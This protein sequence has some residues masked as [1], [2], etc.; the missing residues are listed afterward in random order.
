[1]FD[2]IFGLPMHPLVVHATVVVVPSARCRRD[3]RRLAAFRR[4]AGPL[5]LVLSV[6]SLVLVP[7]STSSGESLERTSRRRPAAPAHRD[8][9]RA[10]RLGHHPGRRRGRALLADQDPQDSSPALVTVV[11]SVLAAV[12]VVG[13]VV[14]VVRIGHSGA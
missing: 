13:T 5:P 4:W 8:G 2:T 1:M 9:R 14:Q 12:G 3:G 10:A 7:L 11:I 6:A